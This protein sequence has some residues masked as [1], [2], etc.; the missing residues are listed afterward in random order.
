MFIH[1]K[2]CFPFS[3]PPG[4]QDLLQPARVGAR[5]RC[6]L[7][8]WIRSGLILIYVSWFAFVIIFGCERCNVDNPARTSL[9]NIKEKSEVNESYPLISGRTQS[10]TSLRPLETPSGVPL[11]FGWG[12][13]RG[14]ISAC[15][16]WSQRTNNEGA[17]GLQW[18]MCKS[19]DSRGFYLAVQ[20][21]F[22]CNG[23]VVE[24]K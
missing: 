11:F 3:D 18:R 22:R 7:A 1:G 12:D 19:L 21:V 16:C 17:H 23:P 13:R 9:W 10:G 14:F 8:V 5:F 24:V 6:L 15:L 2:H 4:H 20:N